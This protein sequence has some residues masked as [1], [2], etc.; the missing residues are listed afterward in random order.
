MHISVTGISNVDLCDTHLSDVYLSNATSERCIS[1]RH[2]AQST[3]HNETNANRILYLEKPED[4]L[5]VGVVSP[6]LVV[7]DMPVLHVARN[8]QRI[9]PLTKQD[10]LVLVLDQLVQ[11]SQGRGTSRRVFAHDLEFQL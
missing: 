1:Q 2:L 9:H 8:Q 7:E 11:L 4:L 10:H 3:C 5:G 6:E